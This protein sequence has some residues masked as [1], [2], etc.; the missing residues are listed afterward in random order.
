GVEQGAA[1]GT[2]PRCLPR[3]ARRGRL[4]GAVRHRSPGAAGP[5]R[6]F[7]PGPQPRAPVDRGPHLGTRVRPSQP[8]PHRAG[9]L[10]GKRHTRR[11]HARRGLARPPHRQH[12][13]DTLY[14]AIALEHAGATLVTADRRYREKAENYGNIVAL[15]DWVKTAGTDGP[16]PGSK[17]RARTD[18]PTTT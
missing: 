7:E 3:D 12:L 1:C 13:F 6:V 9:V 8:G 15:R 14:H 10:R 5:A 18:L 2:L 4:A 16:R 17:R 11:R